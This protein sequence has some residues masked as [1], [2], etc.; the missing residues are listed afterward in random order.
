MKF[1]MESYNIVALC[2]E[3]DVICVCV[4]VY[5]IVWVLNCD[6]L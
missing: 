4:F 5:I 3:Y 2:A 6:K 1:I